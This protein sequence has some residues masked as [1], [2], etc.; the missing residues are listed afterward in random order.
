MNIYLEI[1]GYVGTALVILSMMMTS[2]V[3]LRVINVCGSV[4]SMIYS[5]VCHAYPVAVLNGC[6][7]VINGVQ[8]VRQ[9][10]SRGNYG[11]LQLSCND[12]TLAYFLQLYRADI[13]KLFP[14]YRLQVRENTE[15]HMIFVGGEAVGVLVG[16]RVADLYRIE[17]DYVVPRWRDVRVSAYLMSR[18]KESGVCTLTAPVGS[19][20]HNRYLLRTGF[21][22]EGGILL[23]EL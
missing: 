20:E 10:R 14:D 21:A 5:I 3:R 17:M 18:L 2:L 22:D 7:I 16:T 13:D 23:K 1:F 6:L 19:K 11:H 15:I 9:I 4:I 12:P 8:T